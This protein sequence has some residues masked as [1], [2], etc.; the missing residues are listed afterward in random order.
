MDLFA[1]EQKIY[2]DALALLEEADSGSAVELGKFKELTKNYGRLLKHIRRTM[3]LSDKATGG[4][5]KD[6]MELADKVYYDTLTGIYNRRFMEEALIREIK[7]LSRSESVLS[8][9]ILDV[10]FFKKYNDTYGHGQG[11]ECLRIVAETLAGCVMREGDFAARY[12]GEEFVIILPYTDEKGA[13]AAA[14]RVLEAVRSCNIPH[15]KNPPGYVTV[16]IGVTT[17]VTKHTHKWED[18]IECADKALYMSKQNGRD[19][20]TFLEF[21]L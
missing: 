5:H 19:R 16:S 7:N 13:N 4:L 12:G 2:D 18:Y 3:R 14:E 9:L 6:K 10:D 11:D 20:S 17:V 15:E 21:D 1:E 8:V